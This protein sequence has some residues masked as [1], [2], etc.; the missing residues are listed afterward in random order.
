MQAAT[1]KTTSAEKRFDWPLCYE[2]ESYVLNALESF[3]RSND[4]A[5]DLSGRMATET[6]TLLLDWVDHMVLP[7]KMENQMHEMGFQL[8]PVEASA[9]DRV[10]WHPEAML[11]R[12]ILRQTDETI[13]AL[14][15]DSIEA[16]KTAHHLQERPEGAVDSRFRR[17][18]VS[19]S[20]K[21]RLDVIERRGYRGYVPQPVFDVSALNKARAL[22]HK[23]A[24]TFE[25]DTDGFR[26]TL[27]VLN[28]VL[29]LVDRDLAC[30]LVF[31][32]ERAFWQSRNRAG[33]V[34]KDRQDKP[35]LGWAN[36][37]HHTFR[38]SRE[39]FVDLMRALEMLG[40]ERRERYYA[41]AQAGWG[42][43]ILEQ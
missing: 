31:E 18:T 29:E 35:G 12:L 23:R 14:R 38:S 20:Q 19:Q 21:T 16:F 37:D 24:R 8:E 10:F 3:Q 32:E 7:A 41:G 5:R 17:L 1:S 39:P 36:H 15:V 6:G 30:A 26:Q 11:P 27:S 43:Q 25:D 2:A 42:A 4:F 34:Q 13:V 40:F 28:R 9:G 22:W 33:Q